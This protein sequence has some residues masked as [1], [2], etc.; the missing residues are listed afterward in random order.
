MPPGSTAT[1]LATGNGVGIRC[2]LGASNS[3]SVT[4]SRP[5]LA[6]DQDS[7][8]DLIQVRAAP[9]P[10]VVEVVSESVWRGPKE[11]S[12]SSTALQDSGLTPEMTSLAVGG[13]EKAVPHAAR[14]TA[15][16]R[17]FMLAVYRGPRAVRDEPGT[18]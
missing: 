17:V 1:T 10:R 15:A 8:S 5:P 3:S 11:R 2:P 6:L 18:Q 14:S 16:A 9:T 4:R 7:I 12:C 13:W